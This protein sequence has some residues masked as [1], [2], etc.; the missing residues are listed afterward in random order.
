M[1]R[2][3]ANDII[4]SARLKAIEEALKLVKDGML[5]GLGSGT[6]LRLFIEKLAERVKSEEIEIHFVSTSYDT[7]LLASRLGLIERPLLDEEPEISFDGADYVFPEKWIVKGLGGALFR[8]K[9][10]DY[11][12]KQYIIMVDW[13]KIREKPLGIKIPLEVHPFAVRQVISTLSGIHG[14]LEA[15][16]RMSR[17]GKLGPIV[18][19]NG[20]FIVDTTFEMIE[21]P[22]EL[23]KYLMSIPGV[24]SNGIFSLKRPSKILIGYPDTLKII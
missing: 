23:E 6:T 16:L 3:I 11:F 8:E 21:S 12:S 20:N 9:I 22:E 18:T 15:S 2:E 5:I 4:V 14:V 24:L 10:V 7:S 13:K 19:D 17:E 1:S